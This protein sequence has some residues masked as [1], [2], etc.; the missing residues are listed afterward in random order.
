MNVGWNGMKKGKTRMASYNEAGV[1]TDIIFVV[2]TFLF[3]PNISI[4]PQTPT[5]FQ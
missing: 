1:L 4:F 3:P 5:N 2:Q